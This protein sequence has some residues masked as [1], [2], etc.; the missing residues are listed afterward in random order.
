METKPSGTFCCVSG[1]PQYRQKVNTCLP[2]LSY[3]FEGV[4]KKEIDIR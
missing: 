1:I 3:V 2:L 4:A